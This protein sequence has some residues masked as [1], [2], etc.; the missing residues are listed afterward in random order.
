[1]LST[2]IEVDLGAKLT[3]FTLIHSTHINTNVSKQAQRDG[4]PATRMVRTW[5]FLELRMCTKSKHNRSHIIIGWL[6]V[7]QSFIPH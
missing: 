5:T 2:C 7:V 3:N 1:M 6:V 4:I